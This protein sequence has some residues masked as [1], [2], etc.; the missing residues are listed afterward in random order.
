V[1]SQTAD[2]GLEFGL[3]VGA[4]FA[5]LGLVANA[6]VVLFSR[7]SVPGQ[8]VVMAGVCV[9]VTGVFLFGATAYLAGQLAGRQ[10]AIEEAKSDPPPVMPPPPQPPPPDQPPDPPLVRPPSHLDRA[11]KN[12]SSASMKKLRGRW[13]RPSATV[14][15]VGTSSGCC[16]ASTG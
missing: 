11:K 10:K 8:L 14:T 1:L 16:S 5:L 4:G 6:A 9:L 3:Q 15:R 7:W 13:W 12:G 2:L